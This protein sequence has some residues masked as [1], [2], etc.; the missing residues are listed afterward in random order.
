MPGAASFDWPAWRGA[1][2][3]S[4]STQTNLNW[5]A[6]AKPKVLWRGAVGKGF[7][8]FAVVAGKVYTLGNTDDQDTVFCL[9][10]ATGQEIWKHSYPVQ[11]NRWLTKAA[12]RA[13]PQQ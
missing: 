13:L 1:S 7:S 12:Q 8:S 4:I 2:R 9:D 6:L 3:D 5:S 11:P 10:A